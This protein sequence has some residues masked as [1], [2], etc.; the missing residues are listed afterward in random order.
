[1]AENDADNDLRKDIRKCIGPDKEYA[2]GLTTS[3]DAGKMAGVIQQLSEDRDKYE[4]KCRDLE[5]LNRTLQREKTELVKESANKSAEAEKERKMVADGY[6]QVCSELRE[7]NSQ[8]KEENSKLKEENS[9]LKGEDSQL[10]EESSQLKASV[11][12][13]KVS[14][15]GKQEDYDRQCAELEDATCTYDQRIEALTTNTKRSQALWEDLARQVTDTRDP[16][17]A[18]VDRYEQE[19]SR[20]GTSAQYWKT[21]YDGKCQELK[22]TI[23]TY[24]GG[25]ETL[26]AAW[27]RSETST[28]HWKTLYDGKRQLLKWYIGADELIYA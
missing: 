22:N 13:S 2:E 25:I 18:L 16:Y 20:S 7:N 3:F 26:T 27:K 8:L 6:E 5:H 11:Q 15:K 1:M 14:L 9:Q 19:R 17:Q 23:R 10:K 4:E 24:D 12:S 28:K 21:L